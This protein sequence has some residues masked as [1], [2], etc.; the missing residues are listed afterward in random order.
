MKHTK[1]TLVGILSRTERTLSGG[2]LNHRN[3]HPLRAEP[4]RLSRGEDGD[5]YGGGG[6]GC[7]AAAEAWP[8][9][10]RKMR[11][12]RG[13]EGDGMMIVGAWMV[14]LRVTAGYGGDGRNLAGYER[15]RRKLERRWEEAKVDK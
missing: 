9:A 2:L 1:R 3:E 14:M 5:E 6:F 12:E 11:R 15:G 10:D 7:M 13:G 4:R 8:E